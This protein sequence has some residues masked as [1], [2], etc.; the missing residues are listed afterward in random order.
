MKNKLAV[1]YVVVL[2]VL[3]SSCSL[4]TDNRLPDRQQNN[5]P[6]TG[7]PSYA[8]TAFREGEVLVRA[9]S[10][11]DLEGVLQ[12][13]DSQIIRSYPSIGWALVTVP[14]GH[15]TLDFIDELESQKI[16]LLAEP[17]LKWELHSATPVASEGKINETDLL[18]YDKLWG[19]ENIKADR[20]WDISTGS[21][22]VIIA[23][24]DT[25]LDID[26]PEF[27]DQL[28]IAPHNATD[29]GDVDDAY[30]IYGH[31]THVAGIAAAN[32]RSGKIA[33]VAWD[34]PI[35]PIRVMVP[36]AG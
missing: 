5:L 13:F 34:C 9:T 2:A 10:F 33:G 19:M 18:Y 27:A 3:L 1:L 28:I 30:D 12:D 35:M 7:K 24:I 16:A 17:N 21:E 8:G 4:F 29:E 25:G 6:V 22:N 20:G 14:T 26:H 31:G 32:G 23:I 15:T 11:A 36:E